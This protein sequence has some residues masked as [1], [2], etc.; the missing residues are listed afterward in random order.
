[1]TVSE[2]RS[3]NGGASGTCRSRGYEGTALGLSLEIFWILH[4]CGGRAS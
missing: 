4:R 2:K 3:E 1:M